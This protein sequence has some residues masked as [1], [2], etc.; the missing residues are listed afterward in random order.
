MTDR[1]FA[2]SIIDNTKTGLMQ[3]SISR[4]E[5]YISYTL[6]MA[7]ICYICFQILVMVWETVVNYM[8]R[9]REH[10]LG[11]TKEY[12][13]TIFVTF[14]NIL[15]AL[16]VLETL[17][18]FK[19]EHA[20]KIRIILSVCLIAVSRKILTLDI[21]ENNPLSELTLGA[22]ILS[23]SLG[24]FLVHK[25]QVTISRKNIEKQPASD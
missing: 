12:G 18:V 9:I 10:G 5:K 19:E 25:D 6:M 22:L 14:F 13:K 4:F 15:L 21:Y 11:F 16:E 7:V 8:E 23:L 1:N 3:K 20:I 24:Y 2:S 17:R